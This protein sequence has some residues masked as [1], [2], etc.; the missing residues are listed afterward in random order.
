MQLLLYSLQCDI[1]VCLF[2][3][4]SKILFWLCHCGIWRLDRWKKNEN[5]SK[6]ISVQGCNKTKCEKY[7]GVWILSECILHTDGLVLTAL[8][9]HTDGYKYE[10]PHQFQDVSEGLCDVLS[11]QCDHSITPRNLIGHNVEMHLKIQSINSWRVL[12]LKV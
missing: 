2:A 10:I 3:N 1:S 8:R 9:Q 6:P 11:P 12:F 7:K 4:N 5:E